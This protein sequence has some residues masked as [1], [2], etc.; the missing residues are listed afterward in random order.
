MNDVKEMVDDIHH[1]YHHHGQ[2]VRATA[3]ELGAI[4]IHDSIVVLEK[5]SVTRP[6]HH[7]VGG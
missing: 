7:R 2:R 5:Q 4:H 6:A 1:W 3:G